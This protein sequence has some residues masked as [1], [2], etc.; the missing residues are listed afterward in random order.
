MLSFFL[1]YG[2]DGDGDGKVDIWNNIDD[3]FVFIV[4]YLFIEGWKLGIGW[5]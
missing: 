1:I 2:V 3:V 4:N 5:G